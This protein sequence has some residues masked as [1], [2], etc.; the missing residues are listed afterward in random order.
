MK[1]KIKPPFNMDERNKLVAYKVIA[2]MYFLTIISI[3]GIVIYRQFILGQSIYDFEDIAIIM[4]VN[5]L[6]LV[7]A[8]LYF[9]A[10]PIRKIRISSILMIYAGIV[11]LG[12]LFTYAKY[13]I[14]MDE[15]LSFAQLM[16]KLYIIMAVTGII[17]FFFTVFS[18]LGKR[19]LDKE[20]E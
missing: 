2:V 16:D 6:F 11:I 9:G 5:S 14:F 13:N 7:S 4:T 8:L 15:N 3:Q 12:S 18:Y 10:V 20:I 1:T 17:V 19:K